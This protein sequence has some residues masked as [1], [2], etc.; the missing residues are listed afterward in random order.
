VET[1]LLKRL[2]VLVFIEHGTRRLHLAGITAHPTGAWAAQQAR[3]LVMDL[4]ERPGT[5]R[6]LIHDRDPLFTTAFGEVLKA[7][8]LRIIT[9]L[10]RTPRM[11]AI[12]ERVIGTLRRELLDR[13]LILGERH[14]DLVLREYLTHYN[15]HRPH[16]SRRQRPPDIATQPV[17]DIAD[18]RSVRR[19]PV[20]TGVINEYHRAAQPQLRLCN[21]IFERYT[22]Q[23]PDGAAHDQVG[24]DVLLG[25]CLEHPGLACPEASA[26]PKDEAD[27]ASQRPGNHPP[28]PPA[29]AGSRIVARFH[30]QLPATAAWPRQEGRSSALVSARSEA[31]RTRPE[32][33]SRSCVQGI[34][35]AGEPGQC[36]VPADL[37]GGVRSSTGL[38]AVLA[39]TGCPGVGGA[40]IRECHPWTARGAFRSWAFLKASTGAAAQSSGF[41]MPM[42]TRRRMAMVSSRTTTP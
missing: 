6:F 14:L 21:S 18:L 11:N 30:G 27:R 1:A 17:R 13:T 12:C 28:P 31:M 41:R 32:S 19:R 24:R 23:G 33:G 10:P 34:D 7:E 9:T 22:V 16:Q 29:P 20:V 37:L 25:Q 15:R 8:G 4:D 35:V 26:A 2:H 38:S 36:V 40:R 5:L 39:P 42:A 3:N